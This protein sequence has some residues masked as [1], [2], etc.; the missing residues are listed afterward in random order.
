MDIKPENILIA[1]EHPST[2]NGS[3][4]NAKASGNESTDSGTHSGNDHHGVLTGDERLTYKI[5]DLGNIAQIHGQYLPEE[6]D[7]RYMAPE[8]LSFNVEREKLT[9]ADVFSLGLSIFAAAS[10][11]EL[12]KNSMDDPILYDR[13]KRGDLPY[14]EEYSKEFNQLLRVS[15]V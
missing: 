9:K 6:G 2:P 13:L 14:L 11:K 5:G 7:C 12:P 10:L 3:P 1:L 8:L 15:L 4:T